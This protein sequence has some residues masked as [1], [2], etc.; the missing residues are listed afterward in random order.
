MVNISQING[1]CFALTLSA[2]SMSTLAQDSDDGDDEIL[3]E[4]IGID[5]YHYQ[6]TAATASQDASHNIQDGV[7]MASYRTGASR[8]ELPTP[9]STTTVNDIGDSQM[10][11]PLSANYGIAAPQATV[12]NAGDRYHPPAA[13]T[14]TLLNVA[15]RPNSIIKACDSKQAQTAPANQD[16]EI[17]E[18]AG[19]QQNTRKDDAAAF[20]AA[21]PAEA[22]P[23][24]TR[25]PTTWMW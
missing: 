5:L 25:K 17:A 14:S 7:R 4:A 15:G 13:S 8:T 12:D 20:D 3:A 22:E 18:Q 21:L 6:V 11:M 19:Q 16:S 23:D 1:V 9:T 10:D 2:I 24:T